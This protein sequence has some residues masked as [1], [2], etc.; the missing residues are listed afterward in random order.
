MKRTS[1]NFL[2]AAFTLIE[3]LVVLAVIVILAALLLPVLSRAKASAKLAQCKNNE[4]QMGI[5]ISGFVQDSEAYPKYQEDSEYPYLWFQMIE[6]YAAHKW[7]DGLYDCPG[8]DFGPRIP[9]PGMEQTLT[10]AQGE[11]A[12]NSFGV[13]GQSG[14]GWSI[15]G[16][17]VGDV[18]FASSGLPFVVSVRES[19]VSVP[20]DMIA[21]ADTYDEKSR[22][23]YGTTLMWGYQLGDDAMQQR[24]RAS[25]R[26]RHRGVFNVLF[27]DGHVQHMKPSRLFGQRDD[28][29]S[30]L[31][32][33]H[34]PHHEIAVYPPVTD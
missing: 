13:T 5:A 31:N 23:L 17:G 27:C 15:S 19:L 25:A 33:D 24:A 1:K 30:R 9:T 22:N 29:L 20:S 14:Q 7:T 28:E 34:K 4:R 8:F 3:L 2:N 11:Y 10:P 18:G 21:V 16:L 32:R 26:V 12:Y 6:P